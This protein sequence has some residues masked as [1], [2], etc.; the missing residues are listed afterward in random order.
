MNLGHETERIEFK[1][2]TSELKEAAVSVAAILNKHGNGTLYF[3]VKPNGEVCG[4]DVAEST[5]R[6]VSQAIGCAIN[7]RVHPVVE[8]LDDDE[9]R[10]YVRVDFSGSDAPYAC[11]GAYRIRVADED[12][13]MAPAEVRR[14]AVEAEDRINPWDSRLSQRNVADASEKELRAYIERGNAC[15]RISFAYEGVESTL[16]RL[17]LMREGRLTNAA[18]VLFCE[19]FYPML[20]MAIF[21][22]HQRVD[23]L[24]IQQEQ[25]TLFELARKAEFYVLSSIRRR[26]VFTGKIE[27][28]EIPELPMDAVREAILNAFAHRSYRSDLAIQVEVY[29][30]SVE[31]FSPGWF[32]HGKTP[33]AHL[34][35]EDKSSTSRNKLIAKA[36]FLSKE[37]ESFGT[38]LPRIKKLCDAEGIELEYQKDMNGTTVVFHRN[39]PF[40]AMSERETQA[41]TAPKPDWTLSRAALDVFRTVKAE[42]DLTVAQISE[43]THRSIR[44]VERSLKELRDAGLITRKGSNK[45]G[46]WMV[47]SGADDGINPSQSLTKGT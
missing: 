26:A 15:G 42:S 4:Q 5:L 46:S 32:P 34:S 17:G 21:A 11:K 13:L 19:S 47:L 45:T 18:E 1:K 27:R 9:G 20:K 23:I 33:E 25:S 6:E 29:P 31:I 41:T 16:T 2:S 38:G 36:L 30:D 43:R 3:G 44:T 7:P 40:A 28:D 24:D 12:V 37:I 8:A 22:N 10:R 39:D 14:M 35:G